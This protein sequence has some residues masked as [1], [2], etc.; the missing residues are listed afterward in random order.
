MPDT[1]ADKLISHYIYKQQKSFT[2]EMFLA[3]YQIFASEMY[4]WSNFQEYEY[5]LI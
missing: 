5:P 3:S 1:D 4:L 2:R